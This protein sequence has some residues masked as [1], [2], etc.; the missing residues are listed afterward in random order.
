MKN[1]LRISLSGTLWPFLSHPQ[2]YTDSHV[3]CIWHHCY[4]FQVP[5]IPWKC[6]S[7]C[8]T[9]LFEVATKCA[10]SNSWEIHSVTLLTDASTHPQLFLLPW[11]QTLSQATITWV[12]LHLSSSPQPTCLMGLPAL[13]LPQIPLILS[14]FFYYNCL[15]LNIPLRD[16]KPLLKS[17]LSFPD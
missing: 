14:F 4:V 13:P 17:L 9:T 11:S 15:Y 2:I 8:D 1:C 7:I 10:R 5:T 12:S 3:L 6:Y 16:Y